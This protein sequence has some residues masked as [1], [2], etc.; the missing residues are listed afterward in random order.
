MMSSLGSVKKSTEASCICIYS[1]GVLTFIFDLCGTAIQILLFKKLMTA[2][3]PDWDWTQISSIKSMTEM[4]LKVSAVGWK[5]FF[6]HSK[7][8]WL[9]ENVKTNEIYKVY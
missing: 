7:S 2:I 5:H 9:F 6:V 1:V 3:T 8:I 4:L